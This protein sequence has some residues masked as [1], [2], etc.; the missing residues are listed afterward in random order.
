MIFNDFQLHVFLFLS[1]DQLSRG[2]CCLHQVF[3]PSVH[4][5]TS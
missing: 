1:D 4:M 3:V 2:S 5:R